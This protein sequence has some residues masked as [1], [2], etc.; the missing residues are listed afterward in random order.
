MSRLL[1]KGRLRS[2]REDVV[3]FTSSIESD[4]KLLKEVIRIN[5]A[6][7]VMLTQRK[8]I[9][10]KTGSE[11]LGALR[12]LE[13][14]LRLKRSHEDVHMAVEEETTRA[15]GLETGGNMHVA[16]SRNDQVSTAIRMALREELLNLMDSI[17]KLQD[18]MMELSEEH[19]QTIIPG[20][21]HLQPAQPITFAHYLLSFMDALNRDLD[22]LDDAYRRVDQ[23]PMGAGALATTSFPIS[24]ERVADLLGFSEIIENSLD[25]VSSRDFILETLASLSILAVNLSRLVEDLILWCTSEFRMIDLPDEFAS[26]SSIMPQKKNP[27]TLEITRAR[28]SHILGDVVSA[29]A[30]MKAL[31][32]GYNLDLQEVTPKLWDALDTAGASLRILRSLILSLKVRKDVFQRLD[33]SFTTATE[34]ANML[35]RKYNIP[36][37]TA[38]GI[39]GRVVKDLVE[40]NQSLSEVTP[41]KLDEVARKIAGISLKA[42]PEDLVSALNP[43]EFVE[44]HGARGGPSKTEVSRMIEVRKKLLIRSKG[45]I[46]EKKEK[47]RHAQK[48]LTQAVYSH[49]HK[50]QDLGAGAP[51][52]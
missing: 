49:I 37:R 32:S 47:L 10:Q 50:P 15:V 11:I 38:H 27:E 39:V 5:E 40:N 36:F 9:E 12:M 24:R 6:H 45:R 43:R 17:I 41:E 48:M 20:Y 18:A 1:R 31:P 3:K 34:L 26:T 22:R 25:A 21:T 19:V 33:L 52:A 29:L 4:K 13:K 30:S 28:T 7:V 8:I 51:D 35:V 16:K 14:R 23:C 2:V 44:S 46:S 42:K